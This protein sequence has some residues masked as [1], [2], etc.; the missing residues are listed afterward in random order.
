MQVW[1]GDQLVGEG[2]PAGSR[3]ISTAHTKDGFLKKTGALDLERLGPCA[4]VRVANELHMKDTLVSNPTLP[5]AYE[6]TLSVRTRNL[7][8]LMTAIATFR[9]E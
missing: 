5:H 9:D 3:L 8:I 7:F 4:S 1:A 6:V 2:D